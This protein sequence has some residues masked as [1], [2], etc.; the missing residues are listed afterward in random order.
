MTMKRYLFGVVLFVPLLTIPS[1]GSERVFIG[2]DCETGFCDAG[3]ASSFGGPD[4]GDAAAPEQ[5]SDLTSYCPSNKCPEG[6][7]NCPNSRFPCDVNLRTDLRNCGA[8]GVVCP[9]PTGREWYECVDGHCVPQCLS[10]PPTFDCDGLPDN[11]CE[12][13]ISNDSCGGCGIKCTDPAKPCVKR[14]LSND[15]GCGCKDDKLLCFGSCVDVTT[16]D[17]HCGRC[18]N[19]CPRR[20][21]GGVLDPNA[22]M[23]YGCLDSQCGRP[24][25]DSN[26]GNC[27]GDFGNGCEASLRTAENCGACGN[28][29]APGE[30]CKIDP[31]V[32]P[33]CMCSDGK[34]FCPQ[35]PDLLYGYCVDTASDP[36]N[37]GGCG[38]S[39]V[40]SAGS[41]IGTC[42]NGMCVRQCA[43]GRADCN[44]NTIDGCEVNSDS[45][46]RNCGG[47]GITCDAVAGQACVGGRCVVEPC[48]RD[49]GSAGGPQ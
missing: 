14:D 26:W 18:G 42:V 48:D 6:Y 40:V 39:C 44:G 33:K 36:D 24:K 32:G 11:G 22:H 43:A 41:V 23:Y 17:N 34:T 25:C 4:A 2:A 46:P 35:S 10:Q 9:L 28:A 27:D 1:C 31:Y 16:H 49:A 38:N 3:T 37:C 5:I 29:C 21:D 13:N 19:S 47:C 15:Y 12:A 20:G 45:D 30:E 7:T 8:C